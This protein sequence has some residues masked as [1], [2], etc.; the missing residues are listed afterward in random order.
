MLT[1]INKS[2]RPHAP[3][4]VFLTVH[5]DQDR[6]DIIYS[7][8]Y[9]TLADKAR[10]LPYVFNPF[11][12]NLFKAFDNILTPYLAEEFR[13][14]FVVGFM[15]ACGALVTYKDSKE[16]LLKAFQMYVSKS[17]KMAAH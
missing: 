15:L 13:T 14:R 2:R 9:A 7:E 6:G 1:N 16:S 4:W 3:V 8:N 10:F 12:D 5:A 11:A 17:S